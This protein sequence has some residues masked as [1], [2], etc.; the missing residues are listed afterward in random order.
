[1]I[2]ISKKYYWLK[3]QDNFFDREEIKIVENMPNGKEY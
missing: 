2:S 3:L 1:M